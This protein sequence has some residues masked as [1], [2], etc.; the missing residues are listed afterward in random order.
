[1]A[2][3]SFS[4]EWKCTSI[5]G[6]F[7]K[8][9]EKVGVSWMLRKAGS[10]MGWGVNKQTQKIHVTDSNITIENSARKT[11]TTTIAISTSSPSIETEVE[12]M[13]DMVQAK[14]TRT[15]RDRPVG[16]SYVVH[17]AH[18]GYMYHHPPPTRLARVN[19]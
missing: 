4:G 6:D 12:V 13:D 2:N 15:I 11:T 18:V 3:P 17:G 16:C 19:F 9:M 7:E 5:E 10:G 8:V 1:M 14:V